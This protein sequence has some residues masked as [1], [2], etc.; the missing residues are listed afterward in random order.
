MF[1]YKEKSCECDFVVTENGKISQVI[2]VCRVVNN[3]N[4][5]REIEGIQ[6]A[7][8]ATGA[9]K[10]IIITNNQNETVN[11]IEIIPAWKWFI[12]QNS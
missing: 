4:L 5:K 6:K 7:M 10:G 11:G 9:S 12:N 1:F 8:T 2:Q 3:E